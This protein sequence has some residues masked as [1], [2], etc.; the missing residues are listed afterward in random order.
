MKQIRFDRPVRI[1]F[2][3]PGKTRLVHTVWVASECLANDKWPDHNGPM[4]QM[5]D[6]AL[7][8]ATQGHVT[9]EEAR[10]AFADAALEAR[11]LVVTARSKRTHGGQATPSSASSSSTSSK[12]GPS[13]REARR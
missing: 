7:R 2:G 13:S 11:I 1:S 4:F 9:A 5:A 3:K 12:S 6:E 8:G 10:Q